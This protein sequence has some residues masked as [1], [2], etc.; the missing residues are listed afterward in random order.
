MAGKG[1][2]SKIFSGF[3]GG[4]ASAAGSVIS[5]YNVGKPTWTPRQYDKLAKEA[6]VQNAIGFRCIKLISTAA[7][8]TRFLLH[9][10][11]GKAIDSHALLDLLAR[12]APGVSGA[13]LFEA[14]Y[15][16]LLISGNAYL[17]RTQPD[18]KDAKP[19]ELW[20]HRPDRMKVIAGAHGLPQGYEYEVAGR[21]KRWESDPLTGE[22]SILHLKE[23]HPTDDWYGLGRIEPAA[24]GVDRHNAASA[25]NKALLENGAR[26]SGALIFKP[27][28]Q[29]GSDVSAPSEVIEAARKRLEHEHSGP[30]N[31]GKGMVF[32]GDVT[33]KEMGFSPRDM[34]F[35][36]GKD[37]AARDICLSFGV[38]HI[39][40]VPGSATYNNLKEARLDLH[41]DTVLPLVARAVGALNS[42]LA[43]RF[44]DDL[45]LS[46]DLDAIPALEPR[47]ESKRNSVRGL[48]KDGLL[49]ADEGRADLQY[50]PRDPGS[51]KK[52]DAAVLTALINA[53]DIA[54]FDPLMRYMKSVGL[55]DPAM[56]D[57]DVLA[58]A[59]AH[60]SEEIDEE[61]DQNAD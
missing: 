26:P 34:D 30:G 33:W 61:D 14:F 48:V 19:R 22:S 24:M 11:S 49:D 51:I 31:V 59:L 27:V 18:R 56:S 21:K 10:K 5:S 45:V 32:G 58:R 40:V 57:D 52:V 54:G 47:R 29:D 55:I 23:F 16:Y 4:K 6:Y 38:P 41:E 28:K 7:A 43:P 44:G 39:L 60:V 46:T 37:D 15:S 42:W 50:G 36:D 12:P 2:L 53:V 13:D 8:N 17:E 25:H 3:L 35:G 9:T 1:F 20:T